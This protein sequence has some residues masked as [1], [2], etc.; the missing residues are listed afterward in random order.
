MQTTDPTPLSGAGTQTCADVTGRPEGLCGVKCLSVSG[1][2]TQWSVARRALGFFVHGTG[3][4]QIN[5]QVF[6]LTGQR[7]YSS[8]WVADGHEWQLESTAGQKV[9]NGVYLYLVTVRGFDGRRVQTQVKKLLI[10]R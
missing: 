7:V 3:I 10:V 6:S 8:G 9:A 1:L 2:E 4:K 5:V